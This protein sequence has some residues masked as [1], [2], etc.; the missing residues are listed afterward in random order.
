MDPKKVA[1]LADAVSGLAKRFD[2]MIDA[3]RAEKDAAPGTVFKKGDKI[4][5]NRSGAE[6]ETVV[7]QTE[8]MILT[9]KGNRYH[10]TKVV[11]A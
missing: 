3:E 8:N 10:V 5:E 7:S 4:K 9:N 6:V 2:A 11:R 1:Q